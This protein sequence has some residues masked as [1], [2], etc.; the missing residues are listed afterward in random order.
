ARGRP[1][2]GEGTRRSNSTPGRRRRESEQARMRFRLAL[3]GRPSRY[4]FHPFTLCLLVVT[5]N[6][7]TLTVVLAIY[8]RLGPT[9]TTG[10]CYVHYVVGL[11]GLS[12]TACTTDRITPE[13]GGTYR[14]WK[15]T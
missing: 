9:F 5:R 7:K 2:R 3:P 15:A 6:A 12:D 13:D 4:A 11:G 8:Q 1:G 14:R 10:P